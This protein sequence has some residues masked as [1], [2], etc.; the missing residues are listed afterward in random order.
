VG[1]T[2]IAAID[3]GTTS[4]RTILFDRNLRIVSVSQKPFKQYYPRDGWVEH[5]PREIIRTVNQTLNEALE[6]SGL[7]FRDIAAIGIT[8][9]RETTV[10]WNKKTGE[11]L[12]PAIVWQCRRTG[13]RCEEL[14]KYQEFIHKKTGLILDPYFSATK[15]EWLLKNVPV[16]D[17]AADNGEL[18]FGTIDSWIAFNLTQKRVFA[19]DTSNASRTML[20]DIE[21]CQW[22]EELLHLFGIK[23]EMLPEVKS[24]SEIYGYTREGIPIASIIGDQQGALFGQMCFNAGQGKCTYGTGAFLLLNLG[25]EPKY[26]E[27]KLLTTI[28]WKIGKKTTYAMEGSVFMCGAAIDWAVEALGLASSP[29]ATEQ[30]A[31]SIQD[32]GGVYFIPA[33]TGLGAPYWDPQARGLFIGL[34]QSATKKHCVRSVLESIT[35]SVRDLFDTMSSECQIPL[36]ELKIDGGVSRNAFVHSYQSTVLGIP[37]LRPKNTETTATGAACLAGLAVGFWKELSEISALWEIDKRVFRKKETEVE[38]QYL[39]WKKA[40]SRSM[41]WASE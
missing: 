31:S 15:M 4:T 5:D 7:T 33:L 23:E 30:I 28:G 26:S 24:S 13:L 32:N 38:A 11:P 2:F 8:N 22:D 37:V 12:Y 29:S 27:K 25:E 36:Q 34:T 6:K 19:T 40:V 39:K 3:Q 21:T 16:I 9:Q 35:Y 14:I 1:E 10:A 18:A 41:D 17:I 20:L